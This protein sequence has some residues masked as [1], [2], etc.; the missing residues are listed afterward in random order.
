M[1][2]T[3]RARILGILNLSPDSFS[4]GGRFT[5]LDAALA[6]ARQLVDHGADLVDVG[7]VSSNPDGAGLPPD[8]EIARLAPVLAA[9]DDAGIPVSVDT[10]APE[11]QIWAAPRVAMLNDIRGFPDPAV[12]PALADASCDL[13]VMHALQDGRADR[14]SVDP[15]AVF[16]SLLRFFD[17]RLD[18]LIRA[19][20][21]PERLIVDPGMGFFLGDTPAPSVTV[22]QRIGALRAHTG[23]PV[24]ISVS[25]KSFLGAL[26]GGRPPLERG[27]AT[28]IAEHF[29]VQHGA[30]W[31]RTH[32]PRA[33]RDAETISRALQG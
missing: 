26:L 24:L 25:R 3:G 10:F 22:L 9:L 7:A 6:H 13:V 2:G 17:T 16:D 8:A 21:A 33:L 5:D 14:R 18:A 19:G 31:V 30:T 27:T 15:D 32:D 20:V 1:S 23:R 12:W 11:V 4:D 28:V 29:A